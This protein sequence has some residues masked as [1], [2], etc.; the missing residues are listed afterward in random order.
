MLK[1]SFTDLTGCRVPLQ[2]APMG[3]VTTP[4]LA[5]AVAETGGV[6]MLAGVAIPAPV[7][8]QMLDWMRSRTKGVF[9]VNFLMHF[10]DRE[11]LAIAARESNIVDF[12]YGDPDASL[13]GIVH[14][15]G[16][17]AAWQVGST[18]EALAAVEAGC[19]FVVAQ[20]IEA[21]GH[22]RGQV[23][24]LPLLEDLLPAVDIPVVATGGI[25]TGRSMAAALA[26]GAAAVRVGTR[27]LVADETDAHPAYVD[28]IIRAG[29]EDTALTDR[30]SVMWPDAPHRVLRS[31]IDAAE[32]FQGDVVGEMAVGEQR[33]PLPRFAVPAPSSSTT[34]AIEAMALYAG[35]GVG[36]VKRRQPAADIVR[37]IAGEAERLLRRWA[38]ET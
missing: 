30:F 1:T 10:L 14:E 35:E 5:V 11:A 32:S 36:A 29:P 3:G 8:E 18:A 2:Q 25:G 12:F 16:A 38:Q 20:G 17:L 31:C 27:F 21:G 23:G 7:L 26:A 9:G 24:L 34:G 15:G 37:E 13:V 19:D 28:A 33:V 6:G 4:Q 22:V